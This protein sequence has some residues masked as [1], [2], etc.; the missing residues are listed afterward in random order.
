MVVSNNIHIQSYVQ[1]KG[2]FIGFG[3]NNTVQEDSPV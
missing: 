1:E 3:I 2:A